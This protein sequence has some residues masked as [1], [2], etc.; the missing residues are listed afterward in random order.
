MYVTIVTILY[1]NR[2]NH[3]FQ[4]HLGSTKGVEKLKHSIVESSFAIADE[5][6]DKRHSDIL[7]VGYSISIS[8]QHG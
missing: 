8:L 2:A 4:V 5:S 1:G 6:M 3:D 7:S